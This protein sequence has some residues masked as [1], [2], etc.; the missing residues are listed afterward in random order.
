MTV[1]PFSLVKHG[2]ATIRYRS[3]Y[4]LEVSEDPIPPFSADVLEGI[5][6]ALTAM[7]MVHQRLDD[8]VVKP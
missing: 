3:P 7:S 6:D 5:V 2:F 4:A 1:C 8:A